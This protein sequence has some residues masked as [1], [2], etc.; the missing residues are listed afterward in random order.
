MIKLELSNE[1]IRD[2]R[3]NVFGPCTVSYEAMS[4]QELLEDLNDYLAKGKISKKTGN[5]IAR[6]LTPT[7]LKGWLNYRVRIEL[8]DVDPETPFDR[9]DADIAKA[10]Q[11]VQTLRKRLNANIGRILY[12]LTGE[13]L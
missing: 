5:Y 11:R 3:E 4:N 6:K 8:Y 12:K 1:L 2:I 7:S 9:S 10:K 13:R